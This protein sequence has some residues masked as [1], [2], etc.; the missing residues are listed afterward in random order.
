[1]FWP[2]KLSSV[3]GSVGW[4]SYYKLLFS[5]TAPLCSAKYFSPPFAAFF[6]VPSISVFI[7]HCFRVKWVPCHHSMA[8]PQ[9]AD[10]GDGL[11]IW[12]VAAN[13]LNKQS[14][15]TDGVDFQVG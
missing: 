13:I 5:R 7:M 10:R 8:S 1:M 15:T 12:R 9:F 14:S 6:Q 2:S 4:Y 11:L 3:N